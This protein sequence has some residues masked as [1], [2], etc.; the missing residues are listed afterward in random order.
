MNVYFIPGF[1]ATGRVFDRIQLPDGFE[2]KYLE[3]YIP[4]GDETLNEYARKMAQG[5]DSSQPFVLIGYSFGGIVAQ[6]INAF[7][8]PEKTIIMASVK[9]E[10]EIPPLYRLGRRIKFAE[11]FPMDFKEK[12]GVLTRLFTQLIYPAVPDRGNPFI[13]YADSPEYIKW[14]INQILNWRP[15]GVCPDLYH[16]HGADDKL[17]PYKYVKDAI[18]IAKADHMMVFKKYKA[19]NEILARILLQNE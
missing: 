17:L 12:D 3:W 11:R 14:S 1:L 19:I 7:L 13:G 15:N 18:P 8:K 5:I 10:A 9:S 2:K 4:R 16:I 6:E